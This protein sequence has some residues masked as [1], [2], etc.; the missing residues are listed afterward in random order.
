MPT[1][2]AVLQ[3]AQILAEGEPDL[4]PL[5]VVDIGGSTTDVYSI[6]DGKPSHSGVV[7]HGLPEPH[8]KRTVEGDLGMRHNARSLVAEAGPEV[9]IQASGLSAETVETF[10]TRCD[11]DTQWLPSS[12][13]EEQFDRALACCATRL[14]VTRHAG[15]HETV[16]TA[17]GPVTVQRGKDLSEVTTL[18]G[19]GGVLVHSSEPARIL[20]AAL[21][22]NDAPLSLRPRTAHL[23]LD[24]DY[25]LYA[26]GLLGAVEPAAALAFGRQAMKK[27][28]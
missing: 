3:G 8:A 2:A 25:A 15:T 14:S 26:C 7:Y 12:E 13:C 5:L 21:A 16:H 1:P 24:A 19:T 11:D 20:S 23:L 28:V 10:L 9:F 22:G 4:G 27:L 17:T 18:I 6:C